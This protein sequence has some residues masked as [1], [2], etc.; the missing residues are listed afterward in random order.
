MNLRNFFLHFC[1]YLVTERTSTKKVNLFHFVQS[2]RFTFFWLF[3]SF[4]C[5]LCSCDIRIHMT[6]DHAEWS[7]AAFQDGFIECFVFK[8]VT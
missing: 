6:F 4:L 8:T 2:L 7:D 1:L 5:L 3:F